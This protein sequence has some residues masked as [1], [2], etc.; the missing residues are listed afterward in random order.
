[1][2]ENRP[3]PSNAEAERLVRHCP[4]DEES[5]GVLLRRL[6]ACQFASQNHRLIFAAISDCSQRYGQTDR[7]TVTTRL[8]ETSRLEAAVDLSCVVNLPK[9]TTPN[10]QPRSLCWHP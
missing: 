8:K 4:M 3:L 6:T 2:I 5:A 1:M 7:S 10:D 9:A